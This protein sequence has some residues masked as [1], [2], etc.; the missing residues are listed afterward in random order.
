MRAAGADAIH[1]HVKDSD[2][3]D[4][5]AADPLADVLRAVRAAA[6]GLP[7]GVTTGDWIGPWAERR[8]A[9][10]GW[11]VLP[12]FA[13]VNWHEEGADEIAAALL[14]RGV[15]VEAGLW[16]DEAVAR[17][18]A[19]PYRNRCL[20]VLLELPDGLDDQATINTADRLLAAVRDRH[21]S[22][23]VLLHGEGSSCWP[24]L[25][26][27]DRLGL[28]T[29]V[30][31]EDTLLLPDGSAASDNETLIRLAVQLTHRE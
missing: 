26:H 5:L 10:F 25:R 6:P 29:R 15:A 18:A 24:A 9:V 28:A 19:S 7:I 23:P 1:L 21:D 17:W 31:L 20:R 11:Q 12:E 16:H 3:L 2:G 4:T 14:D 13:S 27:A 30:G 22:V 8:A